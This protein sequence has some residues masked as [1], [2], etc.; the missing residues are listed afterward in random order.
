MTSLI[1]TLTN[2]KGIWRCINLRVFLTKE[3][4]KLRQLKETV[5]CQFHQANKV[6]QLIKFR[7]QP[8]ILLGQNLEPKSLQPKSQLQPFELIKVTISAVWKQMK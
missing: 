4:R 5:F 2:S 6:E 7:D 1:I 3:Q 8:V